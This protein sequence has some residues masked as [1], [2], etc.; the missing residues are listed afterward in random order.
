MVI[1]YPGGKNATYLLGNIIDCMLFFDRPSDPDRRKNGG[2]SLNLWGGFPISAGKTASGFG[3]LRRRPLFR[4]LPQ[5]R[6]GYFYLVANRMRRYDR[7]DGGACE[8]ERLRL[9]K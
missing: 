7:S 9:R 5:K 1:P 2:S 6:S 8:T 3:V 4:R